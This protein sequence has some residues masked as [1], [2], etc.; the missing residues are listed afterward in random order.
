[1][2]LH[3]WAIAAAVALLPAGVGE[4]VVG[5]GDGDGE[6]GGAGEELCTAHQK[7]AKILVS[8]SV[9]FIHRNDRYCG[10]VAVAALLD[11]G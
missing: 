7:Q 11:E 9:K 3:T 4:A 1:M 2:R 6:A 10:V 5:E 8:N